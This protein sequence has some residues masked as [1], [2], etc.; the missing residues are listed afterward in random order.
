MTIK[1]KTSLDRVY[2]KGDIVAGAAT[3]ISSKEAAREA[4]K[5]MRKAFRYE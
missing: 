1:G 3:V 5:A 2:T 4:G